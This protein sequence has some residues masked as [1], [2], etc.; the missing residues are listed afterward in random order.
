MIILVFFSG[1][2]VWRDRDFLT[3]E[4][5]DATPHSSISSLLAKALSLISVSALLQIA[6]IVVGMIYQLLVGYTRIEPGVYFLDFFLRVLLTYI[7][8]SG[9]LIFIQVL[10]NNKYL[11]YFV[12]ILILFAFEFILIIT[13]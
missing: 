6:F 10:V 13:K 12:S 1:E 5:I 3:N 7:C 8:W 2:L 9:I 11:G 4:V